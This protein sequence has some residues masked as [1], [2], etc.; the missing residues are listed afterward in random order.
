MKGYES[1]QDTI[2]QKKTKKKKKKKKKKTKKLNM[3]K[4][5]KTHAKKN[6][7]VKLLMIE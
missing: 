2:Q 3:V 4:M 7:I 1:R 6:G 5:T